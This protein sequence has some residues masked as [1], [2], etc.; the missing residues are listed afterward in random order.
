MNINR[1]FHSTL[2]K[3]WLMYY[4][5]FSKNDLSFFFNFISIIKR[6]LNFKSVNG[7]IPKPLFT[8]K[9]VLESPG[10]QY[11]NLSLLY[12]YCHLG[13]LGFFQCIERK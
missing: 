5:L 3:N 7:A 12:F 9:R 6:S 10:T 1:N 11:T 8:S 4:P 13:V 2:F